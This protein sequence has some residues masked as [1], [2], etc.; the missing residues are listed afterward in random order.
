MKVA[1]AVL[2]FNRLGLL[3]RTLASLDAGAEGM[4][5]DQVVVDG[6]SSDQ[7]Q[8][9]YVST[10]PHYYQFANQVTV[11]ASMSKAIELALRFGPD[12]VVFTA[13]DYDFRS[14]WLSR[15]VSF[16]QAAPA[17]VALC[18]LNWEPSYPWNA[19]E[20]DLVIGGQ[21]ALIRASVPGSSWSFRAADWPA[22]GPIADKTGGEDHE[23]N[24]RLRAAGRWLAALDLTLHTGERVSAWGNQS[25]K[26]ARPLILED[27]WRP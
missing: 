12:I 21:R 7:D 16:W 10:L 2:T 27:G 4:A 20:Q 14:D 18:C 3:R 17:E 19:V 11:G 24:Q 25:W 13:D 5:F 1:V 26:I 9:D 8:R 6:G 22:I 15:L 23:V